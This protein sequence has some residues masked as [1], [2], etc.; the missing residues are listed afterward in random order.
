MY[1]PPAFREDRPEILHALIRQARLALLLSNGSGGVPD[2]TH[3]PLTLDAE[4][5]VLIGHVARANPHWRALR[6]AGRAIAVFRGAEAYVSPNWYPSKAEHQRVVPTWNYE[7]VHAE[8]P[9]EIIEEA[10]RLHAIVS[11]LTAEKESVQPR[12]WAVADAPA[13]FIAG[14]LKGIVGLVLRIERLTGK[15]KLSQNRAA[16]DRDGAVAGLTASDDP[17]DR[18]T[19]AAMRSM[20]E[21]R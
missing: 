5:G 10:A 8:G 2:I 15:R 20:V 13:D 16:Q 17:R 19:A 1:N 6:E 14:Q 12:P 11:A 9:V 21:G 18:A 4:A 7:A 3:L